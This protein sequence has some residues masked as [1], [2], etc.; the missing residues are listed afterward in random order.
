VSTEKTKKEGRLELRVDPEWLEL[1]DD[2]RRH[3]KD[4]PTRAE[5]LRRLAVR[6]RERQQSAA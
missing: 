5:Y 3:E 6:E 4:V 1:V 2:L